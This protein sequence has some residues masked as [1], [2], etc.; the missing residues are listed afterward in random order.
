[1]KKFIQKF[2]FKKQVKPTQLTQKE[3]ELKVQ[4]GISYTIKNYG[5]ALKDLARY[6]RGE[7]LVH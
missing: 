6:D 7:K 1:M 5:G 4:K 2:F 3:L